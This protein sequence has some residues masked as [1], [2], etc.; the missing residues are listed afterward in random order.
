MVKII[1]LDIDGVLINS[2]CYNLNGIKKSGIRAEPDPKCI[3][4][5]NKIIADSNASIVISST[6]RQYGLHFCVEKLHGWGVNAKVV[7]LTPVFK[8]NLISRGEEIY[9]WLCEHKKLDIETYVI[10]DDDEDGMLQ[11]KGNFIKID[12]VT[13]LDEFAA[14]EAISILNNFYKN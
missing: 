14:N 13:G 6:W 7:G 2:K 4:N 9:E 3:K 11:H 12:W 10:L 5:L 8:S 1:F